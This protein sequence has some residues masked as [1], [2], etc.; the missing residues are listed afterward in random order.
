MRTIFVTLLASLAPTLSPATAQDR[1]LRA[2]F[3]EV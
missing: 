3:P 2:D 1:P